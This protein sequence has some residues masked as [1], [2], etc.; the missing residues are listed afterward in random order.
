MN[1]SNAITRIR[2]QLFSKKVATFTVCL[3][4]ASLLWVVHALNVNYRYSLSVPVQFLNLP[5]NKLI[6]G[7]LP[8]KLQI[9]IKASGLKLLLISFRNNVDQL[10]IDFNSLKTN[11]KSQAYSISN[12]NFNLKSVIN[13]D[14]E[15]LK[16]RPDTL[17]F[18]LNKGNSKLV[19]VKANMVL[20]YSPGYSIISKPTVTPAYINVTG[21][22]L[23]LLQLDTVYTQVLNLKDVHQN[24]SSTVTLKKTTSAVNY[25]TKEV[26][27]SFEVDRLT[28]STLKIP[29]QIQNKTTKET[30]KLMPEYVTIS[31]LVAMKEYDHIDAN[32]FKATVNYNHIKLKQKTLP[33]EISRIPSEVKVLKVEPSTIS[34]LIYK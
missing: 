11:A 13:F 4:V 8:E 14:V 27:V 3:G 23:A 24:Y 16:I 2:R 19:P 30:I 26:Q 5:T 33:V 10:T 25:T 32:S 21:D 29:I 18:S 7:D 28:E 12:G 17:F 9:D 1:S 15:I 22:S 20:N 6:V 34:Y 31:Y